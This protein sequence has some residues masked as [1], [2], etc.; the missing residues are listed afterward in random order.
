[1]TAVI[2]IDNHC[3]CLSFV[4][5]FALNKNDFPFALPSNT[6]IIADGLSGNEIIRIKTRGNIGKVYSSVRMITSWRLVKY[7]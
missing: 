3:Y 5:S 2:F 4:I 6:I 1:M 7:T